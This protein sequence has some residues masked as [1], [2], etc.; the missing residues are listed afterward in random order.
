[1]ILKSIGQTLRHM[2]AITEDQLL[3]CQAE[4]QQKGKSLEACLIEKNTL[5]PSSVH[6]HTLP[7]RESLI[8]IK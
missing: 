7:T 1:M 6:R 3:E 4:S 8:L 2:G 5:P